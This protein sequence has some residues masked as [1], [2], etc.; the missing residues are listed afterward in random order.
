MLTVARTQPHFFIRKEGCWGCSRTRCR[1]IDV[2]VFEVSTWNKGDE[3]GE[4][5]YLVDSGGAHYFT[6][7]SVL[8]LF[9]TTIQYICTSCTIQFLCVLH[10][11][12][13]LWTAKTRGI[14]HKGSSIPSDY[15][16]R[17][18]FL[19]RTRPFRAATNDAKNVRNIFWKSRRD[20]CFLKKMQCG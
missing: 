17:L 14:G 13:P 7:W 18:Y 6:S 10:L 4:C 2:T 3:S 8:Y 19:V 5:L 1:D 20:F 11:E 16:F 12:H 15:I 9:R